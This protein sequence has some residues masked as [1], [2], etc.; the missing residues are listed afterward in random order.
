MVLGTPLTWLIVEILA[1]VLFVMCVIHASKHEHGI[2]K[3]LELLGFIVYAGI[4]ENIGVYMHIYDYNLH[5]IMLIGK[6]PLE[7]LM[8]EAVIFYV[9]FQL[10]ERLHIPRWGLP[11]V[12]GFL[13]SIQDMTVDPSAVF[14]RYLLDGTLSGQWNWTPRYEG[15]FF[16]IPF[17]N[18][19]GWMWM[20]V[21]YAFAIQIGA[22]LYKK[23]KR[24]LIGYLYPFVGALLAVLLLVSPI[25]T[26]FLFGAP[27]FPFYTRGAEIVLLVVN[28]TIGLFI[29]L[30][31]AK[32]DRPFDLKKDGILFYIPLGLHLFDIVI[33]FA[34]QIEI[35]YVPV[36]VVSLI[37][38][39]YLAYLFAK[40]KRARPLAST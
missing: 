40:G 16:G 19:S 32:I 37:H 18:F 6:V 5:R 24:D 31:T 2:I 14:D 17:F 25:T 35:A 26:F 27:F 21:Y 36:I 38:I 4:Y 15:A 20:M 29:L 23:Y 22:W 33:A 1:F 12:V 11:F 30:R 7:I 34:L 9:A 3:V 39:A 8:L 28:F 10:A 13:S